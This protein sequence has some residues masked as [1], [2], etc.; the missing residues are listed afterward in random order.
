MP[1]ASPCLYKQIG[2]SAALNMF[3]RNNQITLRSLQK[4]DVC[5]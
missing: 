4:E 1:N 5:C 2:I 3:L